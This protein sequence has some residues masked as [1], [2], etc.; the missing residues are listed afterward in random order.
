MSMIEYSPSDQDDD[1]N[2]GRT[3]ETDQDLAEQAA[4]AAHLAAIKTA[5]GAG[6]TVRLAELL[7]KS[8]Y[9][10]VT[11]EPV[12]A[13]HI[14]DLV[15]SSY[16]DPSLIRRQDGSLDVVPGPLMGRAAI[17]TWDDYDAY[18]DGQDDAEQR[19]NFATAVNQHEGT[20]QA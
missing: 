7:V 9:P 6:D 12:T 11:I 8:G 17:A 3:V 19:A 14:V 1:P 20:V 18:C 5:A 10:K 15:D 4:H 16:S 13:E 2:Y